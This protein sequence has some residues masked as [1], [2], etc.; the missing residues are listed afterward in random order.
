MAT[1]L[2]MDEAERQD[3]LE[4][5]R[6]AVD[7][8]VVLQAIYGNALDDDALDDDDAASSFRVIS[9]SPLERARLLLEG[10]GN[11]AGGAS[12]P[13]LEIELCIPIGVALGGGSDDDGGGATIRCRLPPRYPENAATV[14]LIS[15][16]GLRRS[17]RD[18][19]AKKLNERADESAST[20]QE[21]I[22]NVIDYLKELVTQ[23]VE[24][25]AAD[26][27]GAADQSVT[28]EGSSEWGRR[29]IWVHHIT[30]VNR[31]KSI[32]KEA[33]QL[34]LRGYLK[35]GYPGIVCIEGNG[36]QCDAFVTFIKGNKS[37][38]GGFGRNWGHHVRGHIEPAEELLP[39]EE[40][41]ELDEDLAVLAK[42]CRDC[43]LE[44]EFKE[45]V[46]QHKG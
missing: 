1:V 4:L 12:I 41:R 16:D 7:E 19:I 29:W 31:C 15:L 10:D 34:S 13:Q 42:I 21:A 6:R 44:D 32:V 14:A 9:T 3:Q 28:D 22:L 27:V 39:E 8:V 40:F 36:S 33:R 24:C 26:A 37:R 2:A 38:P 17:Y 30:D 35:P 25:D 18:N 23:Y 46:L 5:L 45:Y 11:A 20:G 43:H